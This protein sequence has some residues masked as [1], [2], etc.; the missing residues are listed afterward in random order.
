VSLVTAAV[1]KGIV[2][3]S[4]TQTRAE[5]GNLETA[6]ASFMADFPNVDYIP[7]YLVLHEDGKWNLSDPSEAL[8]FAYLQKMF[9]KNFQPTT[10]MDWNG[11]LNVNG[12][13]Q[14]QI[15][16][17]GQHCLVFLLGGIPT[18][19]APFT[20]LGFS[21]NS[22]NPTLPPPAGGE[23]RRGPYFPFQAVRLLPDQNTANF[24]VYQDPWKS[25]RPY[26]FFSSYKTQNGY[27]T[28]TRSGATFPGDCPGL[29]VLPYFR[30]SGTTAVFENSQSYQIISAGR[31]GVFGRPQNIMSTLAPSFTSLVN[32]GNWDP[33][34]GLKDPSPTQGGEDDQS[35]FSSKTLGN[36]QQ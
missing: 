35:N 19:T 16:L 36:P 4:E 25:G 26:A 10:I 22:A 12:P 18:S 15:K 5:I 23:K 24:L 21:T 1:M 29:Q 31:D 17:Q 3:A 27:F 32:C 7:S 6:I 20:C 28:G 14:G 30:I 11:D 34:T 33:I 2:V 13:I 8:S 9:G